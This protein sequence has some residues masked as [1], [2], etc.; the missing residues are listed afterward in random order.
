MFNRTV[1]F[2]LIGFLGWGLS[3]YVHASTFQELKQQ[4]SHP[5]QKTRRQAARTLLLTIHTRSLKKRK[6]TLRLL[7][8]AGKTSVSLLLEGLRSSHLHVR[9]SA[10]R[11]GLALRI[12]ASAFRRL[13]L[14]STSHSNAEMRNAA[15]ETLGVLGA[16]PRLAQHLIQI[17]HS[18]TSS[19]ESVL[20]TLCRM[21]SRAKPALAIAVDALKHSKSSVR[22]NA[23]CAI[24]SAGQAAQT[25]IQ[26]LQK[27]LND[28]A[29]L[30]R[31]N[32][33][34]ILARLNVSNTQKLRWIFP[35]VS[36]A[37]HHVRLAATQHIQRWGKPAIQQ[38]WKAFPKASLSHSLHLAQMLVKMSSVPFSGICSKLQKVPWKAQYSLLY[39]LQN[40]TSKVKQSACLSARIRMLKNPR[41]EVRWMAVQT[42]NTADPTPTLWSKTRPLLRD[43]AW[44]VRLASALVWSRW[45]SRNTLLLPLLRK[46]LH[47]RHPEPRQKTA[48]ALAQWG[49]IAVPLLI[50][51]TRNSASTT[52]HAALYALHR[53][54]PQYSGHALPALLQ[55]IRD[56]NK[57]VRMVALQAT[58][59][60][61]LKDTTSAVF[62]L[63]L[64]Y[65]S[66]HSFVR[67]SAQALL[68]GMGPRI[69]PEL[70]KHLDAASW[71]M[72]HAV[73]RW[74]GTKRRTTQSYI[75]LLQKA[76]KDKD[77]RVRKE[78]GRILRAWKRKSTR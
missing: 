13:V 38:I 9:L 4:L 55:A 32:T 14:K 77:L 47:A 8:Q 27:T 10:M 57:G 29:P 63:L 34:H 62:G 60:I 51:E 18:H 6:D 25:Y 71:K 52:R 67:T 66:T 15:I 24:A 33:L 16:P 7:S 20:F 44:Q 49:S 59:K 3:T 76:R 46:G 26:A 43:A 68:G 22:I 31:R 70:Q 56:S 21:G 50:R 74:I 73:V 28:P 72:R 39:A 12:R 17:Y 65:R 48:K 64:A 5:L 42:L 41:W 54:P 36:D 58:Q 11:L 40:T 19:H 1:L 45:G 61:I 37:D 69:L 23:T 75:A 35:L 2:W 53:M 78:A 30:V